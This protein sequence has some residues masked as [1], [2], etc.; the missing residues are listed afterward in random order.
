MTPWTIA[1][2]YT[3]CAIAATLCNL[4]AQRLVL[5]TGQS[6]VHFWSAVLAGTLI[7][8]SVK[9]YLDRRWIFIDHDTQV[10]VVAR[11]FMLYAVTGVLTTLVFWTMEGVFW[12]IYASH[13][14][15]EVGAVIGLA[16]GYVFKYQLDRR[17]VF[18]LRHAAQ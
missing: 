3:T 7:G 15:R 16:L 5:A 17:Y 14:M 6:L 8:L 18:N 4:L 10:R 11:Q 2:R 1:I 13:P 9:Y 12:L